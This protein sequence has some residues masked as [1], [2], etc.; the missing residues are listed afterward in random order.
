MIDT[1]VQLDKYLSKL[2]F[3]YTIV[4][5]TDMLLVVTPS[6]HRKIVPTQFNGVLI[7]W[8]ASRKDRIINLVNSQ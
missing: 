6:K 8:Q 5:G 4:V 2:L 1:S 3:D 7:Q